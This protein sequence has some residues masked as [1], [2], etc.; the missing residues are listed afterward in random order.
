MLTRRAVLGAL[1]TLPLAPR[2]FAQ[3]RLSYDLTAK[4][5]ADGIWMVEG[6][7]DYFSMQNGGAIVNI[8]L[9]KGDT[10]LILIDTGSS[11]RY[12]EALVSLA[13]N[14]DIRGI[15]A[16]VN[17]HHHPDHFFGNQVF[18]DTP[19]FALGET[20][21]AAL[22]D[23]DGFA[24]NMY[25]LLGDWMRGTEVVP[26]TDVIAGGEVLLDG[27]A[28]LALPLG[29]HTVSDLALLDRRTGTLIAGDLVFHNRAPTTPSADLARWNMSL[30][31]LAAQKPALIVPGHG[32]ADPTGA[33]LIQTR[34]YLRWLEATLRNGAQSGLD[35]V[36][37]METPLPDRFAT[38]GA[39]PQEYQRS[40]A[41]LFPG[42]E[43]QELPRGN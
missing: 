33:A 1:S 29:G 32:P 35:M 26:P 24:D 40:V 7:T 23:G 42:I 30:D 43:R 37:L 38:M 19:I 13:R 3:A 5:L 22:R 27:R 2:A 12:G 31:T 21:Q 4:P 15:S 14:L 16:V 11:R 25:R 17:T 18:A 36:E 39:Q 20:R 9:I 10:G 8:T 28:F 34:D 41:H 6:A